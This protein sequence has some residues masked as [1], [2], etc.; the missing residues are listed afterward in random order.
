MYRIPASLLRG[1]VNVLVVGCGG[2]G[3]AIASGLPFLH[4][5]LIAYTH[6]GGLRVSL[7]DD[8]IVSP[9]NCVRQAFAA[10]EVGLSKSVVIATRMNAFYGFQWKAYATRL[11]RGGNFWGYDIVIGCVDTRAARAEIAGFCHRTGVALWLDLGNNLITGQYVLGEPATHANY[12]SRRLPTVLD[13]YPELGDDELDGD[14]LPSC[15]A[16]EALTRQAPF[17][18]NVIASHALCMLAQLF[19]RGEIA[20]HGG[21]FDLR[22]ERGNPIPVPDA[23]RITATERRNIRK[24]A[25]AGGWTPDT[26]REMYGLYP[27]E[28][29][30]IADAAIWTTP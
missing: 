13:L 12:A 25:R 28:L 17:V 3:S 10:N 23:P 30:A 4:Q 5:A 15:S 14:G 21:H 22:A 9:A 11:S 2:N 29:N 24:I 1:P 7:I 16:A 6:P 8:D 18:N 20:H 26:V 19:R 27:A